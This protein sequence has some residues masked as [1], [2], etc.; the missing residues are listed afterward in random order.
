M[1]PT[2]DAAVPIRHGLLLPPHP[3]SFSLITIASGTAP[4]SPLISPD[5][6][7][8]TTAVLGK[9]SPSRKLR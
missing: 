8:R 4:R 2:R 7:D 9:A 3:N 5:A 6:Y 1:R